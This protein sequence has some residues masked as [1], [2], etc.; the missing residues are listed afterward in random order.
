MYADMQS[1]SRQATRVDATPSRSDGWL[2]GACIALARIGVVM[3]ASSSIAIGEGLAVGPFYF[4][5]RHL[6]FLAL[7]LGL[8][9]WAMRTEPNTVERYNQ[10]L[11]LGC[12]VLLLAV[13]VPGV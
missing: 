13:F 7:G 12:W 1:H 3:V 10:L 9:V 6:V 8:A 11:L 5:N 4:L 2:L